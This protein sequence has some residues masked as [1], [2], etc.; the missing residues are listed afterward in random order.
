MRAV[1]RTLLIVLLLAASA[2]AAGQV[3]PG[4]PP[5]PPP[6]PSTGTPPRGVIL[7]FDNAD[8]EV[9]TQAAAEIAGFN[10]VFG[11]NVR[12]RKV[13]VQTVGR[14]PREEVLNLFLTVLDANGLAAVKSDNV[15][16]II[17]REGTPTTAV[18][19][20]VG[21][22]PAPELSGSEV[23]T[24]VVPLQ[25]LAASDAM[26]LL[27]PFVAA[28]GAV[29]A[30]RESNQVIVTDTAA[31][32]RRLLDIIKVMDVPVAL[33]APEIIPLHHADA[34]EVAQLLTQLFG[35]GRAPGA[36]GAAPPPPPPPAP[37]APGAMP[38]VSVSVGESVGGPDRPPLIVAE[39][40]SNSLVVHARKQDLAAIK[41]LVERLDVN[42]R[43]GQQV[44]VYFA[45]NTK[46][47]DLATTL[48][49]IYG[50]GDRGPAITG[51]QST[52]LAAAYPPS[53]ST[54]TAP[55]L[56][57]GPPPP[58]AAPATAAVPPTE[59]TGVR[60]DIRFIADEVTNAVIVTTY[61]RLWREIQETIKQLDKMPRQVLIQVLAVEITL[62][63]D[64]KLGMDWAV[65]S[66]KF[67]G[68]SSPSGLIP[69]IPPQ[70]LI[71]LGG[72]VPAGLTLFAFATDRFLAALNALATHN[73][74]NVL[75]NPSVMTTENKRAVINVSQSVPIVTS[76]QVPVATGGITGNS[77]TQ[78]VEYRD[79]G[80]ILTVTPRIGEQGTV[81]MD[82]KQEVN[83]V[84][85]NEP[86]PINSPRFLKR[87]AETS[88][89]L[90]NNQ[91]LVLGGLIQNRRTSTRNGVPLLHRIPVIGFL[92][93]FRE[94]RIEKTELVLVIT[95]RVVGTAL[96]AARI[97][98]EMRRATPDLEDAIR[99]APRPLSPSEPPMIPPAPPLRPPA[100]D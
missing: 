66:G 33:E 15:Y 84:G 95:P 89:V 28:E 12:G 59:G 51:T 26:A 86:P 21:R 79:A 16:R 73:L 32:V 85:E 72:P 77:I 91:T 52:R 30:H 71:P 67:T 92:F 8:I 43:G 70:S 69:G 27:R 31:N 65:R 87:E 50:K 47:R 3:T 2:P 38:R 81:A 82:V 23:V 13:T 94:E 44:F 55:P 5:P 100:L 56:L 11:P 40:R 90:L 58:T 29:S 83:E 57:P 64:T 98:E 45:E 54:L 48:D 74:V 53:V 19:T 1:A 20:V 68:T 99:R 36:T 61:P 62:T 75:S 37:P 97:T 14:I 17:V 10:Y 39:R 9:V 4:P 49:A 88:V 7:N 6:V 93:G 63:D 18:R 22:D 78:T 35:A 46:A 80:V 96:E 34:Q 76:A 25:F 60:P 41:R 42:L 24:Q